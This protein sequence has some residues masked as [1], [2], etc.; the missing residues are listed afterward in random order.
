MV[1]RRRDRYPTLLKEVLERS[2]GE[3]VVVAAEG[4]ESEEEERLE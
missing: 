2:G 4:K 3:L 1:L